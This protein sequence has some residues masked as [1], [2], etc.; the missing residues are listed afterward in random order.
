M[1]YL[2]QSPGFSLTLLRNIFIFSLEAVLHWSLFPL[3]LRAVD[4][5]STNP[6]PSFLP[7]TAERVTSPQ[8]SCLDAASID[9]DPVSE[10]APR[11]CDAV[12]LPGSLSTWHN[13]F[14]QSWNTLKLRTQAVPWFA[15]IQ[16]YL[17][18]LKI[19]L[20]GEKCI[21]HFPF[22]K[23][24]YSLCLLILGKQCLWFQSQGSH[25]VIRQWRSV[26]CALQGSIMG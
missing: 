14:C 1:G 26:S 6:I 8:K 20:Q 5:P 11:V 3:F 17:K 23:D 16:R 9:E 7:C 13:V 25:S 12:R 10:R 22:W 21:G 15:W 18:E 24:F 4:L 19:A 2:L